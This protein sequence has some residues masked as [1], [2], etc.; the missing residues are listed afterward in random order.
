MTLAEFL[1]RLRRAAQES[2]IVIREEVL[3]A[4]AVRAKLRFQLSDGS[5][6]DVFVNVAT[7]KYYYHW[8]KG[9]GKIY[10]VNNFPAHGW[11]EHLNTEEHRKPSSA[12]TPEEFF[13]RVKA[14]IRR[15]G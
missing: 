12:I 4:G 11:H 14:E 13:R 8:Q 15:P 6:A 7:D 3:E 2:G 9:R 10:R 1:Q 5:Y